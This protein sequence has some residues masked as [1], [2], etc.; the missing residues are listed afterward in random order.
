MVIATRGHAQSGTM[1]AYQQARE[2]QRSAA[3]ERIAK[4]APERIGHEATLTLPG[5]IAV[6]DTPERIA[7]RLDRLSSQNPSERKLTIEK[8]INTPDFVDVHFLEAGAAAAR[9]V[10]RVN[11]R[12]AHG[13]PQGYGTGSL[14]SPALLLTNQH[15]L[16]SAEA[17]RSSVI[18]FDYED[19]IDGRPLH[20]Q[21][22]PFD[23]DR[24]FLA[25]E[26]RDFALVAVRATPAELARWGFNRLI[27]SEGKA[28]IGEF[29]TI[30]Q[31]PGGEKKQVSLREN[32]IVDIPE[33]YLHYTTD[34]EPGSSGSLAFNDS[35]EA[36]A[37]HHA[38]VE[39]PEQRELGGF[40]NEGI[41]I[42]RIIKFIREAP[43]GP[44]QRALADGVL[45]T[46]SVESE[47]APEPPRRPEQPPAA[48]PGGEVTITVPV[49]ITVRVG[50]A[51]PQAEAVAIDPDYSN[52][53]GYDPDFL[54]RPVALPVPGADLRGVASAE[55]RYH[56]FSVV[57]H[58]RRALALFTAVNIDGKQARRPPERN[59]WILDPRLPA[60][61]QTGE[62]VYRDNPLDRGHLVRRLDP[63]WGSKQVARAAIDDTF[64]FTNAAPQHREFNAGS[65]LWLG[66]E[67]YVLENADTANLAVSVLTGPCS[68]TT[69]TPTA[70]SSSRASSGRSSR[71][72]SAT[73]R[74]RSPVTC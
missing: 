69:T 39:S 71:W 1:D 65:T 10:G 19:G 45:A 13:R 54:A 9:A 52:R 22:F 68:R 36:V 26:E 72:S 17:A 12:D 42:S 34:T 40:V 6:A 4:R 50:A 64:H 7:K 25:D 15:V 29:V 61:E 33:L 24:F 21:V 16:P 35:W 5:G 60:S 66:L 73:G 62:A 67:D 11:I 57:M 43:L 51:G 55:L 14:V 56:H 49:Q 47:S 70:A 37:L 74:C 20:A 23:P 58:R 44:A 27:E 48:Q 3:A 8:V 18:E 2:R 46:A 38:S 53:G 28:I 59:R 63:A 41:R 30:V 32:R 31:H